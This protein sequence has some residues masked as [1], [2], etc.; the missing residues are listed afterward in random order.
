MGILKQKPNHVHS[1]VRA[2]GW[3][4]Y[5]TVKLR[6]APRTSCQKREAKSCPSVSPSFAVRASTL[7]IVYAPR[8]STG[9]AIVTTVHRRQAWVK[10]HSSAGRAV[11][12]SS[13]SSNNN[14]NNINNNNNN[15]KTTTN[16]IMIITT[17]KTNISKHNIQ[18]VK[19]EPIKQ[20]ICTWYTAPSN[21]ESRFIYV[22]LE[23]LPTAQDHFRA[24][25]LFSQH[26]NL[27]INTSHK[28]VTWHD[29]R[30]IHDIYTHARF[31]DL[32]LDTGSQ[33]F[34]RGKNAAVNY[35]DI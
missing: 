17:N 9:W 34:G 22:F 2:S 30:L 1:S 19:Y 33:W 16:I 21:A 7:K 24:S 15:N 3:A 8:A 31:D 29:S 12:A 6:C 14:N 35:L 5:N 26:T 28:T 32:D 25:H 4:Q 20:F 10:G 11:N 13:S 27:S 18:V 23:G